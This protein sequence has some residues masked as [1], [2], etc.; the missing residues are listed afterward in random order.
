MCDLKII[1]EFLFKEYESASKLT[2]HIDELRN[3]ITSFYLTFVT[4]TPTV[5][6]FLRDKDL[7]PYLNRHNEDIMPYVFLFIS[8]IGFIITMILANLRK[9]Q[10]EHFRIINNI[11]SNYLRENHKFSDIVQ[12]SSKTLPKATFKSGTYLWALIMMLLSSLIFAGSIL[13]FEGKL[14]ILG[15]I[16]FFIM[17][18]GIIHAI[19]F[20]IANGF[21]INK[22]SE[23]HKPTER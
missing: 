12:L 10:L 2:F 21:K 15:F 16:I 3:K 19:Y 4:I 8:I 6:V 20:K 23:N 5:I 1:D 13:L 9:V 18:I 11:R 22:Y 14:N 7:T 17:H